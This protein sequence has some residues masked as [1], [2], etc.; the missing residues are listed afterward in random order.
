VKETARYLGQLGALFMH[1]MLFESA[2]VIGAHQFFSEYFCI[3]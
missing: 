1:T 2:A 3:L